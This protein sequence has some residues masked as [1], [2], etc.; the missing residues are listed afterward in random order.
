MSSGRVGIV[1]IACCWLSRVICRA[2]AEKAEAEVAVAAPTMGLTAD[3]GNN[4]VALPPPPPP[5]EPLVLRAVL[6]IPPE[7]DFP[8]P[9]TEPLD[10][11]ARAPGGDGPLPPP[12]LLGGGGAELIENERKLAF[13]TM[14]P[15]SSE[16]LL[17]RVSMPTNL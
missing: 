16:T 3:D 5:P 14:T 10:D 12:P 4:E 13:P 17:L 15:L 9:T 11:D 7:E 6:P 1:T 2:A 8:A